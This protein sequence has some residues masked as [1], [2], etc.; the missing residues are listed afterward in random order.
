MLGSP[1]CKK[2]KIALKETQEC[3]PSRGYIQRTA[4]LSSQIGRRH[5]FQDNLSPHLF[6]RRNGNCVQE[7]LYQGQCSSVED[8]LLLEGKEV[9]YREH[10]FQGSYEQVQQTEGVAIL[11]SALPGWRSDVQVQLQDER[12]PGPEEAAGPAS[13]DLLAEPVNA[14][15]ADD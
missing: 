9:D 11:G 1:G 4:V 5:S 13:G 3:I 2:I 6:V 15:Q 8:G 14:R 10:G 12:F 7:V